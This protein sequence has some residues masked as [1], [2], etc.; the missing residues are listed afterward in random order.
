[1][2]MAKK[3]NKRNF[4]RRNN[5]T[6]KNNNMF[7]RFQIAGCGQCMKKKKGGKAIFKKNLII[8]SQIE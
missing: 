3:T 1:M 2:Y 8:N 4:K 7:F 5:K 6:K